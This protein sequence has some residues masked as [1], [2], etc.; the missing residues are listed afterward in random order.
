ME[1]LANLPVPYFRLRWIVF[2][3]AAIAAA[4][5]APIVVHFWQWMFWSSDPSRFERVFGSAIEAVGTGA[6]FVGAGCYVVPTHKGKVAMILS[7]IFLLL[8]GG[9]CVLAIAKQEWL[10]LFDSLA[11]A[12]AAAGTGYQLHDEYS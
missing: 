6:A 12:L 4:A 8:C 7:G 3:P 10:F 1:S 11:A 9:L 5:V 2:F